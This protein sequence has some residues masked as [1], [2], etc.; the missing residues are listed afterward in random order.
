M[1]GALAT[2]EAMLVL[3]AS[4]TPPIDTGA[5]AALALAAILIPL[6]GFNIARRSRHEQT[7]QAT[8][9][10]SEQRAELAMSGARLAYFEVDIATGKGGVN[11]RWHELL[12]T[13][14]ETV[15][16]DIHRTWVRSLHPDDVQRVLEVGRRYKQGELDEYEVEYRGITVQGETR[17][18][19]SKGML[20]DRHDGRPARMIGVFLDITASKTAEFAKRQARADGAHGQ[21]A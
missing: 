17:W 18:F 2:A 7:R 11:S 10:L 21:S 13:S 1:L 15:G 9:R 4:L 16:D 6:V 12:G 8:L 19:A 3:A 20:I 14:P 5:L